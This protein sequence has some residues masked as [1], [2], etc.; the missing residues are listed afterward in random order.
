M[1]EMGGL[2]FCRDDDLHTYVTA[3]QC[4]IISRDHSLIMTSVVA[5]T[6]DARQT[7]C[8]R[9]VYRIYRVT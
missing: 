1:E 9:H 5:F 7:T 3:L 8:R 2:C 4:L 6:T